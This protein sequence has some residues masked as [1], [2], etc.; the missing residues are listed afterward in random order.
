MNKRSTFTRV[1][2][3][4]MIVNR[5]SFLKAT[6]L[7]TAATILLPGFARQKEFTSARALFTPIRGGTGTFQGRG[8]TIGWFVSDDALVLVDTQF[9]ESASECWEGIRKRTSRR[10]DFLINSHHHG[11]HTAG[12]PVFAPNADHIVAHANVP[13]LQKAAAERGKNAESQVY[14]DT[15]FDT[16]WHQD[17]GSEIVRMKYYGT[18]HTGGDSVT[19]FENADVAHLGDLVFNRVPAYIDLPGGSD[20]ANWI[21]VLERIHD[22]FSD[23]TVFI[24]GHGSAEFGI[25]GTRADLLDAR[26]FLSALREHVQKGITAGHSVDELLVSG[27]P[28]FDSYINPERPNTLHGRIRSVYVELTGSSKN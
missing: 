20:T 6:G 9:P 13:V 15:L 11:D 2:D 3:N 19:H 7:A 16:E 23:E 26:D 25:T 5:R 8:G 24:Y 10:I 27:L 14:A 1:T 21:R 18:A 4:Q 22:D 28:G 12:N 17:F